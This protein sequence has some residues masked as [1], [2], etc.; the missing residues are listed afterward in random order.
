MGANSA[1]KWARAHPLDVRIVAERFIEKDPTG[2]SH[3]FDLEE[4]QAIEGGAGGRRRGA[5]YLCVV[6]SLPPPGCESI[7][8]R[9]PVLLAE[10]APDGLETL[11]G[12]APVK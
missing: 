3:R 5:V 1:G 2:V 8:G 10:R 9:W 4:G 6:T 11:R 7:H 12:T